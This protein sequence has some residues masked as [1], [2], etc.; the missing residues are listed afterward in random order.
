MTAGAQRCTWASGEWSRSGFVNSHKTPQG[1]SPAFRSGHTGGD[2][3]GS[4]YGNREGGAIR[5]GI[6]GNH[7]REIERPDFVFG[8]AQANYAAAFTNEC[9][10]LLVGEGVCGETQVA[11]I[12]SVIII[13]DKD[14]SSSL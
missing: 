13:H 6:L 7:L 10:H 5:T 3:F 12:F 1:E 14:A 2:A 8:D 4:L 9:S 11:F